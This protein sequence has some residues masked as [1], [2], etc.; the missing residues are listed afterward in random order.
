MLM[1][2]IILRFMLVPAIFRAA[3]FSMP[4]LYF[5]PL[6]IEQRQAATLRQ[7]IRHTLQYSHHFSFHGHFQAD[8]PHFSRIDIA[9]HITP[10]A[11]IALADSCHFRCHAASE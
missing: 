10:L 7:L 2:F 11:F 3:I 4:P 5:R 8:E 6:S 9:S 1:L